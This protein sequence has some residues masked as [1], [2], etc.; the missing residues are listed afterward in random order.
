MV[1]LSSNI[2]QGDESLVYDSISGTFR[3]AQVDS[4]LK[5]KEPEAAPKA[6]K[7]PKADAK[8]EPVKDAAD[9]IVNDGDKEPAQTENSITFREKDNSGFP[10]RFRE[11]G[12]VNAR[13]PAKEDMTR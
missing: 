1:Q 9:S 10:P 3:L 8:K 6:P 11:G 13:V 7:A 12:S 2:G 4:K 5:V